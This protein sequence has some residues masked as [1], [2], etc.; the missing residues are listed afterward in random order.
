MLKIHLGLPIVV[1]KQEKITDGTSARC[2][3]ACE[4]RSLLPGLIDSRCRMAAD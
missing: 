1:I 3:T 4:A 2:V